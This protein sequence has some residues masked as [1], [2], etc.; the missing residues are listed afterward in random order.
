M[1]RL[2]ELD[3]T[4]YRV[5]L[6]LTIEGQGITLRTKTTYLP[7]PIVLFGGGGTLMGENSPV[8]EV[9][10]LTEDVKNYKCATISVP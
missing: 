8:A 4:N 6:R 7:S 10:T 1:V 3:R 9:A 5:K 2:G